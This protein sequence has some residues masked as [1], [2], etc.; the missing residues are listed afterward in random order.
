MINTHITVTQDTSLNL[1][2]GY[3]TV[4]LYGVCSYSK[5]QKGLKLHIIV[6]SEY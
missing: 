4:C 3:E 2:D 6:N 5:T 1:V